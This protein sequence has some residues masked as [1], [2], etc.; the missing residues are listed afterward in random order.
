MKQISFPVFPDTRFHLLLTHQWFSHY[1]LNLLLSQ[2]S[3]LGKQTLDDKL[4]RLQLGVD[5]EAGHG[6]NVAFLPQEGSHR[7]GG[8]MSTHT[9]VDWCRS[10]RENGGYR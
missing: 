10:C 4:P 7:G 1:H 6:G 9:V 5:S 3:K 8:T 2:H